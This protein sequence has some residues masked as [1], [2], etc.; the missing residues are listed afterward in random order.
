LNFF[1]RPQLSDPSDELMLEAA[2]NGQAPALVT[3]NV[4][5]FQPAAK[6]F[7]IRIMTPAMLLEELKK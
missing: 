2:V 7:G 6:A 4:R 1:W 3:H 5:D